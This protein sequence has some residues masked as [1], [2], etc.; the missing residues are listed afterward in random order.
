MKYVSKIIIALVIVGIIAFTGIFLLTQY[1]TGK[2][3]NKAE[4]MAAEFNE[5]LEGTWKGEYSI[6]KLTFDDSD[7]V[8]LTLLGANVDGEYKTKYDLESETYTITV[9]YTTILGVSVDLKFIA[10]L[11]EDT[12]TL[13]E[14]KI[15]SIEMK[16]TRFN[17]TEDDDDTTKSTSAKSDSTQETIKLDKKN[18]KIR[19]SLMGNWISQKNS[20]SGY[21]FA[22]DGTVRVSLLGVSY[23]GTYTL[24]TDEN[25]KLSVTIVYAS[26][27]GLE[28]RNSFYVDIDSN[29]LTFSE[30]SDNSVKLYYTR[31][32]N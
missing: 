31:G 6:S 26:V 18:E 8:T 5:Q 12:L 30:V 32:T 16:Y 21:T 15:S 14:K 24:S 23:D 9:K 1:N 7:T 28:V 27:A 2:I 10:E 29:I 22:E 17:G 20:A 4:K 11:E 19:S 3:G 25:N 13:T